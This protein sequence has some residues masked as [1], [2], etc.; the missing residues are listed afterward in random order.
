VASPFASYRIPG[1]PVWVTV[2]FFLALVGIVVTLRSERIEWPWKW[3]G[4]RL[5]LCAS[6]AI[7]AI[8]PFH[9]ATV[10]NSLE[11]SVL[12]VA[13]G[14]SILVVSPKGSTLLIDGGGA[15]EGFRGREEIWD[16]IPGKKQ[17]PR[18]YGRVASRN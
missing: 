6:A 7:I 14:D 17:F 11:I 13:Q 12:D 5:M 2:S 15:F 16:R 10:A 18:I 4:L 9:P 1:A 8:Y 3:R